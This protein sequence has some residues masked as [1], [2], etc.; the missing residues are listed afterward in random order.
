MVT[1]LG[2]HPRAHLH[3]NSHQCTTGVWSGVETVPQP[4][5]PCLGTRG[6]PS[7]RS[8]RRRIPRHKPSR[9]Q[10][11]AAVQDDVK[12]R[13]KEVSELSSTFCARYPNLTGG[14]A[15]TVNANHHATSYR[16]C[17]STKKKP[18]V[19]KGAIIVWYSSKPQKGTLEHR[20]S[21]QPRFATRVDV[22]RLPPGLT[23]PSPLR[24]PSPF[25]WPA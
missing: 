7:P 11:S 2:W 21:R 19:N 5:E 18:C 16:H 25:H 1:S 13:K 8:S 3:P 23:L 4:N 10:K 6:P 15:C 22:S 20:F 14:R 12:K 9:R 24:F 17:T